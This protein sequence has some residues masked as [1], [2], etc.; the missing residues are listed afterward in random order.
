MEPP[1]QA[2]GSGLFMMASYNIR[3]G[4]NGGLESA[5]RAMKLMGV[6][7]G[8]LLQTKLT[9][10]VYTRWSSGY[11]VRATHVPSTWQGGISLFWRARDLYEV[12][13]VEMQGPNVLS[14]LLVSGATRYYTVGCY[15]PPN[16]LITLTHIEQAWMACPKGCLPIVLGDLN[17]NLT[18]PHNKCNETIAKQVDTMNLVDMSSRFRQRRGNNSNGQWTWWMRRGRRW[19]SSQCDYILGRAA[20]LRQFRRVSIRMPFCHDS[21]HRALVAKIRAGRGEEMKKYRQ[22]YQRFLL[23]IPRG[24]HT[25]LVGAYEELRLDVIPFLHRERLANQWIPD[26][27]WE[28][29]DQQATLRRMGNL[30]LTNAHRISRKIKA[31][32]AANCKQHATNA[33]STVESHLGNGAMKE[34]WRALKGWYRAA[35]NCLPPACPETIAKQTAKRMELYASAPPMGTPLPFNFPYFEIPDGVPTNNKIRAVVSGL[36]NGQAG[37]ATV[38]QAEHVKAWLA[39]I[40]HEEKA[41]RENPGRIAEA[42]GGNLGKKWGIFVKMIQTIWDQGEIPMQMS[43]MVI[44]LIPKGGGNFRGIGILNPCWKVV[45]KI[46]V[47]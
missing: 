12:K 31:S 28:V 6:N 27:S 5:L 32:L 7:F 3:S 37:G 2:E 34:A 1:S 47:R 20:N 30:P 26:K 23:R 24:P 19:V 36:K 21:D 40:R 38:M 4:H 42:E 16:D 17:I 43:W 13:E 15:I 22:R 9:K 14:F 39:D 10:G 29:I 41:A 33:A 25:E 8:I 45:E 46:M 18:A 11:H 35:E 44:V